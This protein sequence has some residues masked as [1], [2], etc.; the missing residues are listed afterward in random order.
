MLRPNSNARQRSKCHDD[1]A[2][3]EKL[4]ERE[5]LV[6]PALAEVCERLADFCN[7]Q[8]NQPQDH[9]TLGHAWYRNEGQ[10]AAR[11][12]LSLDVKSTGQNSQSVADTLTWMGG[13]QF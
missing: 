13:L 11:E 1:L 10:A 7:D 3:L 8:L 4:L 5:G 2:A 6:Y 9:A 12:K